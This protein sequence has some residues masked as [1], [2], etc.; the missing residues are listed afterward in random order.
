MRYTTEFGFR[1]VG[2]FTHHPLAPSVEVMPLV[3][4]YEEFA[5]AHF[6]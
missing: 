3:A 5:A 2:P 6:A 4:T 1:S